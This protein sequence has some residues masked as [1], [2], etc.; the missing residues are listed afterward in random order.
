MPKV[1]DFAQLNFPL[2]T[3]NFTAQGES[4]TA[5]PPLSRVLWEVGYF[6]GTD[7]GFSVQVTDGPTVYGSRIIPVNLLVTYPRLRF[8]CMLDVTTSPPQGIQLAWTFSTTIGGPGP[9]NSIPVANTVDPSVR[10]IM[11]VS[12]D[13]ILVSG[14]LYSMTET[15]V[16]AGSNSTGSSGNIVPGIAVAYNGTV[17]GV[18]PTVPVYYTLEAQYIDGTPIAGHPISFYGRMTY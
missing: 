6:V 7:G 14:Q 18:G 3:T 8:E 1:D 5:H 2:P 12:I 4:K 13:Y 17:G 16:D 11:K 10:A 9:N 15:R